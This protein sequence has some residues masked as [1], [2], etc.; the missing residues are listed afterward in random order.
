MIWWQNLS[1]L[2]SLAVTGPIGIAIAVWLLV[3]KSWRLTLA[4]CALFGVGMAAVVMTKVAFIGWGVGVESVEFA[5]FS[6]HAMRAAAVFPVA[7]FLALR[8]QGAPARNVGL[9][10]GVL[11]AVLI[12]ISRVFVDA[13]SVS[14]AVTGCLLGLAVAA[15]F[16]WF[17]STE[18]HLALSR[19]LVALCIPIL[20][21]SPRVEPVPTEQWVTKLALM[22]SGRDR[23]FTRQ[24]WAPP[25]P[26]QNLLR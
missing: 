18:G 19:V 3:G 17:A 20:L 5:G 12:S 23:P 7:F 24:Q 14:E 11:L 22:L 10:A 8:P 15:G 9:A 2:G 26:R 16:V 1:L 25:R 6:G 4:W 13:H 21:I